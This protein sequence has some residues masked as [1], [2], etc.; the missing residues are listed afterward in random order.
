LAHIWTPANGLPVYDA[1]PDA[2][3]TGVVAVVF[4]VETAGVLEVVLLELLDGD[5]L[6]RLLVLLV[7][8]AGVV[9][10]VTWLLGRHC[11]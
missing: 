8:L 1:V 2:V 5:E 4:V 10:V 9:V 6:A 11:E 7:P 3:P